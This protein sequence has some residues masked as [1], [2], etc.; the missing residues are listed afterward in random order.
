VQLKDEAPASQL[1]GRLS[2]FLL[3]N[4]ATHD[5]STAPLA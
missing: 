3:G 4:W 1:E 5:T 2:N